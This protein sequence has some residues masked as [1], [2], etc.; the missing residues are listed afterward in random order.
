MPS[1]SCRNIPMKITLYEGAILW[2]SS[3]YSVTYDLKISYAS[4]IYLAKYNGTFP[5]S[6][7]CKIIDIR[8]LLNYEDLI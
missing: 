2:F 4:Q 5:K 3:C 8:N 7:K 1:F 6:D